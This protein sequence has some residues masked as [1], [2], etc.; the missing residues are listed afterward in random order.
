M[1]VNRLGECGAEMDNLSARLS[2]IVPGIHRRGFQVGNGWWFSLV[3]G[4]YQTGNRS[5]TK[6]VKVG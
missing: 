2:D 5:R 4:M 3:E 1:M 6:V